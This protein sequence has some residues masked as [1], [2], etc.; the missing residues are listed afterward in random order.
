MGHAG[1]GKHQSGLA[2]LPVGTPA[3]EKSPL[4]DFAGLEGGSAKKQTPYSILSTLALSNINTTPEASN[5]Q[6]SRL[7]LSKNPHPLLTCAL[8][9]PQPSYNICPLP[10]TYTRLDI[11]ETPR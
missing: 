1:N 10:L 7:F 6:T 3:C 11:D 8:F 4:L 2:R 9:N 5:W